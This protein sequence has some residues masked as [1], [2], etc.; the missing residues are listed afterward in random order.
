[1]SQSCPS[2]RKINCIPRF[3]C[4]ETPRAEIENMPGSSKKNPFKGSQQSRSWHQMVAEILGC[5]V[6][7]TL[8]LGSPASGLMKSLSLI[9]SRLKYLRKYSDHSSQALR[10][11]KRYTEIFCQFL[12][13]H[14]AIISP[15][16]KYPSYSIPLL[17]N[18]LYLS[19]L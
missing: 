15:I 3:L 2:S 17:Y 9:L 1:M 16:M 7:P 18:C 12:K 5:M 4:Q 13:R 11:A 14:L 8:L 6:A 19:D 10:A